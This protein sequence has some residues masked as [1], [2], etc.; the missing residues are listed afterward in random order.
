MV[1]SEFNVLLA[2]DERLIRYILHA[3]FKKNG[4]RIDEAKN[5]LEALQLFKQK[6]YDLIL[7][8]V[9]MPVMDGIEA[10]QKIR[11]YE[12]EQGRVKTHIVG[13]STESD[14]EQECLN[15]GMNAFYTKPIM[16]KDIYYLIQKNQNPSL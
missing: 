11:E 15:N 5:G 1:T 14:A 8:D 13:I 7:M 2:D 6:H 10:T 9:N 4:C 12:D 3:F 16:V